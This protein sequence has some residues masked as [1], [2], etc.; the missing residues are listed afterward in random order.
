VYTVTHILTDQ[1]AVDLRDDLIEKYPLDAPVDPPVEPPIIEPP[2][3]DPE[4]PVQP[5]DPNMQNMRFEDVFGSSLELPESSARPKIY[6]MVDFQIHKTAGMSMAI[7]LPEITGTANLS[8]MKA[9]SRYGPNGVRTAHFS[10]HRDFDH[11]IA[12]QKWGDTALNIPLDESDSR[13][14]LYLNVKMDVA[15]FGLQIQPAISI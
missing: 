6:P 11:P 2:P 14:V 10:Y 7:Q 1:E 12:S 9:S 8:I 5:P 13:R 4:P 3:I 15:P